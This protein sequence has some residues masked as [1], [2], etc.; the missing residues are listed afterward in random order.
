MRIH[1]KGTFDVPLAKRFCHQGVSDFTGRSD[2]MSKSRACEQFL[3]LK[4]G[5]R[6]QIKL[7]SDEEIGG[8][9][10]AGRE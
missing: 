9:R 3:L 6:I 10:R 5:T 7:E 2:C 4:A 8:H 1:R